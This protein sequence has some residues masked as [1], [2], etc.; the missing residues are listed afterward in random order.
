MLRATSLLKRAA[1]ASPLAP[2]AIGPYSQAIVHGGVLYA[3]GQLGLNPDSGKLV[4]GGV[5]A[6]AEQA[7]KNLKAVLEEGGSSLDSVL[8][9]TVLLTDMQHYAA[10][11][12]VYARYFD[13]IAPAR[14]AF[15][16]T[17]LPAGGLVEIE[18]IA[19]V[20]E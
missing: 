10:V 13:G 19:A 9:T 6:E 17:A 14:A 7:L 15:A 16:V 12:E 4:E 8:K 5:A 2:A 3:S 1:V 20:S 18:A 11:N